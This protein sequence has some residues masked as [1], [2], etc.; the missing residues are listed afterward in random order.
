[1]KHQQAVVYRLCLELRQALELETFTT[2]ISKAFLIF[3]APKRTNIL[4]KALCTWFRNPES[5][6]IAFGTTMQG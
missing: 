6:S 5:K 1:M 2:K 3:Q 4:K